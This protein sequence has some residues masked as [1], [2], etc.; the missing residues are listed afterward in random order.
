MADSIAFYCFFFFETS[1]V[2]LQG[3]GSNERRRREKSMKKRYHRRLLAILCCWIILLTQ[4]SIPALAEETDAAACT[5]GRTVT[6]EEAGTR[7]GCETAG[8]H[9]VI[10]VC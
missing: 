8:S 5:H 7:A 3:T 4:V 9:T 10:T 2:V 1:A 6:R